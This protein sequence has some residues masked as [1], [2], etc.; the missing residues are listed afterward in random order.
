MVC[1]RK[2]TSFSIQPLH[3]S[4]LSHNTGFSLFHTRSTDKCVITWVG[5]SC[6]NGYYYN[7]YHQLH[8]GKTLHF[9]LIH[10]IPFLFLFS[11]KY[12]IC[13]LPNF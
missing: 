10:H 6:Q 1:I 11:H 7:N 13:Y 2:R 9:Q 4:R 8:Q 3:I 5:Y 12:I